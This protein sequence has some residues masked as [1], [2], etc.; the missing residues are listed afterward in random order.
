M[1]KW[2]V[3]ICDDSDGTWS[4]AV[5]SDNREEADNFFLDMIRGDDPSPVIKIHTGDFINFKGEHE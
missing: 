3:L 1:E 2:L 5:Q 4:I